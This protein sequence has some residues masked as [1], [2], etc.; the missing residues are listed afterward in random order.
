MAFAE[1]ARRYCDGRARRGLRDDR[2]LVFARLDDQL[3]EGRGVPVKARRRGRR[4]WRW[5]IGNPQRADCRD[6]HS[7]QLGSLMRKCF[8][9]PCHGQLHLWS[10]RDT[11]TTPQRFM[12]HLISAQRL[13]QRKSVPHSLDIGKD[14]CLQLLAGQCLCRM[15]FEIVAL[16]ESLV[17]VSYRPEAVIRIG[18]P[19]DTA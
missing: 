7:W 13:V 14:C 9:E 1:I 3:V 18:S 16:K 17:S 2:H 19:S 4:R 15:L 6:G 5:E 12:V 11:P 10:R 8:V